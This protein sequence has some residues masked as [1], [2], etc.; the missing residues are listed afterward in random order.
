MET[1]SGLHQWL[2]KKKKS[3][4]ANRMALRTPATFGKIRQLSK[5]YDRGANKKNNY[6]YG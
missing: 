4:S 2:K 6:F 3:F 1:L 5:C